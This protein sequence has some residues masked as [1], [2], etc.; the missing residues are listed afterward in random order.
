MLDL[1]CDISAMPPLDARRHTRYATLRGA[2]VRSS[3]S[4]V[5]PGSILDLS[6]SGCRLATQATF[7]K[8]TRVC[9]RIEGM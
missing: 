1:A 9:I 4:N 3:A 7:D 2:S 5:A 8:G 6:V